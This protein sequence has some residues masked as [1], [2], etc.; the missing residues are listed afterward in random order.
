MMFPV[1]VPPSVRVWN[2]VVARFPAAVRYAPPDVPADKEAVGEE[3]PEIFNIANLAKLVVEAFVAVPPS[4]KSKVVLLSAITPPLK[5]LNAEAAALEQDVHIGA[6][7]DPDTRHWPGEGVA[8]SS[9]SFVAS[10]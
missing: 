4:K 7:L 9:L 2:A 5:T 1:V 3:E 8:A 6:E 10:E